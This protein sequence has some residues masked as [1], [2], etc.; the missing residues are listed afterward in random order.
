M[1]SSRATDRVRYLSHG[2][3]GVVILD[4]TAGEWVVL[5]ETAG[6]FWRTWQEGA[7]F[8]QA[9]SDIAERHPGVPEAAIRS[10]AERLR[11]ELVARKY[12]PC[13]AGTS[14]PGT[15]TPGTSAPGTSA[16]SQ[17]RASAAGHGDARSTPPSPT[18]AERGT[19]GRSTGAAMAARTGHPVGEAPVRRT[20]LALAC[21]LAADALL[22]CS[23]RR[24]VA[25]VQRSRASWCRSEL[26]ARQASQ[27]VEAVRQAARWYPGRAACLERSLA[28]V[29]LAMAARRRLDW[30]IG[31][32][33]DPYRFHAWVSVGGAVV[34]A[35]DDDPT[36]DHW[37][38]IL[39]A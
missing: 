27:V 24:S 23:F 29:L 35:A 30:C 11:S 18:A 28:A 21:L 14:T 1:L 34:P 8:E 3:G 17:A 38:L 31:A 6:E 5:N 10:D 2:H 4:V 7:G 20:V 12:L 32:V 36:L 39:N 22:R 13:P 33:P 26:P 37:D 9:V 25:L 15:S 16:S 19:G